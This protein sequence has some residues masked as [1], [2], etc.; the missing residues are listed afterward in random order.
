M[1]LFPVYLLTLCCLSS[2]L[3]YVSSLCKM[4]FLFI[5]LTLLLGFFLFF[6]FNHFSG[7]SISSFILHLLAPFITDSVAVGIPYAFAHLV[8]YQPRRGQPSY[9]CA[10]GFTALALGVLILTYNSDTQLATTA[11]THKGH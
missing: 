4:F 11:V 10:F 1:C 5:L 8:G 2:A 3:T 7:F 9:L 6:F